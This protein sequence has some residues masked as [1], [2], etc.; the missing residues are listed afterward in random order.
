MPTQEVDALVIGT[1][2]GAAA[3]A[4]RLAEA[5]LKVVMVEKGP[6]V[7]PG[8]FRQTQD[9][10]YITRY[11]KGL[12][13]EHLGLTYAEALGGGSGF[14]EM[15]SLR[16]PSVAFSQID[17][18]SGRALWPERLDRAAL[19]PWYALAERMLRV[20]QIPADEVP[21]SG[22]VF[23]LMLKNLGVS[24]ER[25]RYAVQGCVGSGFC[26]TG[27]VYGAKQSLHMNYLPQAVAAGA[28]VECDR[29]AVAIRPLEARPR[30]RLAALDQVPHRYEVLTRSVSGGPST[31]YRARVV[32]LGGGTVGTAC[33][34]LRSRPY[35]PELSAH[36]G[37]NIAFNGGV[38]V[39]GLLSDHLPDGDM[40]TG[41]SHAGM[42]SYHFLES[43]GCT[44]AAV[45]A[46]P[47][48]IVTAAR[49]RLDGDD[50]DGWWG[51][52]QAELMARFR[53]R[54]L[55]IASFGLT[56]PAGSLSLDRKGRPQLSFHPAAALEEGERRTRRLVESIFLRNGCRVIQADWLDRQGRPHKGLYFS[57]AH[58]TGSARMADRPDDGV[59]D[60]TGAVFGYPGLYV[61][62]G[63]A[64]PASLA[65]NTSLTILANA[66][67]VA[68][69][70]L[71]RHGMRA[72]Q[73][74]IAAAGPG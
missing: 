19:D 42:I 72:G 13:G 55:A 60:P 49:F 74:A 15:V 23:S 37:R 25:A 43:H 70:I 51:E 61:C 10:R 14:Y 40:F 71:E 11:L 65:V 20:S 7:G 52:P 12:A 31:T 54:V 26:V 32:V 56:P 9:P 27:C 67:R 62:D 39:A 58:Q 66:E 45:K 36:A 63:A 53:H 38:K 18:R 2:F 47:L 21:R 17:G 44:L 24:C 29:E 64:I 59:V 4:L 30:D 5:G 35:L 6:R 3:P 16:A 46:L 73:P 1:G 57:S 69:G 33:L 22:L 8:D 34:L 68:A 50:P 28:T 48:Q 41:R